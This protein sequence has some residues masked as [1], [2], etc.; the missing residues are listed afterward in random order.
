VLFG[1]MSVIGPRPI[2]TNEAARYGPY[3]GDLLRTLPGVTGLWQVSGRSRTTYQRRIMLDVQYG[4]T[5]SVW[6]DVKILLRTVPAVLL[7]RGAE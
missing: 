7:L 6:Q 2:V 3:V 1:D 4:D 5:A